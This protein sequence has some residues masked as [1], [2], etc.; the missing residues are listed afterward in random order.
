MI[1]MIIG[2]HRVVIFVNGVIVLYCIVRDVGE[3]E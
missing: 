3:C 2:G 1:G